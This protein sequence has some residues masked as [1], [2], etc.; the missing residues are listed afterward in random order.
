MM[1]MRGEIGEE[2]DANS[3]D[4]GDGDPRCVFSLPGFGHELD[5]NFAECVKGCPCKQVLSRARPV[6]QPRRRRM[7]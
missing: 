1:K 4:E 6:L 5:L 2:E 7:C 3:D